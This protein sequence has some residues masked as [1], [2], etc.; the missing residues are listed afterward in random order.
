[1]PFFVYPQVFSVAKSKLCFN[2][3]QILSTCSPEVS[4]ISPV[5]VSQ[6]LLQWSHVTVLVQISY[7]NLC[8]LQFMHHKQVVCAGLHTLHLE[9]FS[10]H[11]LTWYSVAWPSIVNLNLIFTRLTCYQM[12]LHFREKIIWNNKVVGDHKFKNSLTL[13]VM[14]SKSSITMKPLIHICIHFSVTTEIPT[15]K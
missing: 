2:L 3:D 13:Q 12:T 7:T 14:S 4:L 10:H 8:F 11:A 1:M 15:N 6:N 5:K 9:W